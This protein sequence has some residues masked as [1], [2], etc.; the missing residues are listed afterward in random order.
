M[1]EETFQV[2]TTLKDGLTVEAESR[3]HKVLIDEPK[4]L[5]GTDEGMNPLEMVLSSFGG[6]LSICASMFAKDCGV[7]LNDFSVDLEG[8]LDLRG[9]KGADDVDAG[10]QDVRFTIN[11]DSD[12][13]QENIE[14]LVEM[15]EAR[16]P[17]S[18]SLKRNIT[19]NGDYEII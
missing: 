9:F 14:E 13:P 5:G 10:F 16:C 7:E 17:V 15:I 1:S 12:S 6:C 8:D 4:E 11:I 3:G 2:T 19:V 18:D